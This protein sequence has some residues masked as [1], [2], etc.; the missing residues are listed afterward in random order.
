MWVELHKSRGGTSIDYTIMAAYD[1]LTCSWTET[2]KKSKHVHLVR[3]AFLYSIRDDGGDNVFFCGTSKATTQS[4][5]VAVRIQ[6][7]GNYSSEV[8]SCFYGIFRPIQA[9][10]SITIVPQRHGK[11]F[12]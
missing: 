5:S 8:D 1:K 10:E 2:Q 12:Q 11:M 3:K 9:E 6:C 7:V 4:I